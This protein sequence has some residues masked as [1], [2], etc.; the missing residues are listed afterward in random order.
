MDVTYT[1]AHGAGT[2]GI[3]G[4]AGVSKFRL[5]G[6]RTRWP[7]TNSYLINIIIIIIIIIMVMIIIIIMMIIIKTND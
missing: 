3:G 5:G 4:A 7:P 6:T 2:A 1:Y